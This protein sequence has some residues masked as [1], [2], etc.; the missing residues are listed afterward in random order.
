VHRLRDDA[1]D[2]RG[3]RRRQALEFPEH[4]HLHALLVELV[5]FFLDVLFEKRHQRRHFTGGALPVLL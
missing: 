5:S 2:S 3:S 4:A 1:F